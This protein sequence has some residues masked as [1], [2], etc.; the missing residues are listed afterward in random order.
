M[1]SYSAVPKATRL[2][3]KAKVKDFI[4]SKLGSEARLPENIMWA[5]AQGVVFSTYGIPPHWEEEFRMWSLVE[6]RGRFGVEKVPI[7]SW[8]RLAL[9]DFMG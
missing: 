2:S 5:R 4:V 3:L 9:S 6:L 8:E 7:Q 1:P